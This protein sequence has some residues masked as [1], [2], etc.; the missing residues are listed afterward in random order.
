MPRE[1]APQYY[2]NDFFAYQKLQCHY[3]GPHEPH[4]WN[5]GLEGETHVCFG[6]DSGGHRPE[7]ILF[8]NPVFGV[9]PLPDNRK[10]PDSKLDN[11][12]KQIQLLNIC[13]PRLAADIMVRTLI[14]QYQDQRK[15]IERLNERLD[16]SESLRTE[17]DE[18][19]P[20]DFVTLLDMAVDRFAAGYKEY[21]AGAADSLGL[22]GQWGDLHRK[23]NKLRRAFWEGDES[24]LVRE[25]AD[26]ILFDIIG[27]ALLALEMRMRNM[28]GGRGDIRSAD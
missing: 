22:A 28:E 11:I 6:M 5:E 7:K 26:E 15:D 14:E 1:L 13:E 19:L 9:R 24:Y 18:R 12:C 27:H 3:N 10:K 16:W 21:G 25:D 2:D 23:V 4:R 17:L 20:S 8:D